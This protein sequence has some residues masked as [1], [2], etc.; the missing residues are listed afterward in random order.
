MA[1]LQCHHGTN[2]HLRQGPLFS[3]RASGHREV[4]TVAIEN[5]LHAWIDV[6]ALCLAR[7]LDAVSK[8]RNGAMSPARATILRDVSEQR[9]N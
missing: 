8:S 7:D 6:D 1:H 9:S 5:V 4:L 3:D 2:R